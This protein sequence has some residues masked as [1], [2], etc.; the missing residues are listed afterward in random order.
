MDQI[1]RAF[2]ARAIERNELVSKAGQS[3]DVGQAPHEPPVDELFDQGSSEAVDVHRR[4][5]REVPCCGLELSETSWVRAAKGDSSLAA[6]ER[7]ATRWTAGRNRKGGSFFRAKVQ[8]N[9][10]HLRY[11]LACLFDD[12]CVPEM[13]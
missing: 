8:L 1:V 7:R 6:C 11:D 5:T 12:N 10:D 13:E 9:F 4:A 3:K 2:L